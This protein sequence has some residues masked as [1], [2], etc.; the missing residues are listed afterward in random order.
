MAKKQSKSRKSEGGGGKQL[1]EE[2]RNV[3]EG[4]SPRMKQLFHA[5]VVPALQEKFG[6]TNPMAQPRLTKIILNVGMGKS[7]EGAKLNPAHKEQVIKDLTVISGQKPIMVRARKS[8]SNFK[9]REGMESG[10]MVTIRGDRMWELLDRMITLAIPRIKDF[11]GLPTKS[12]DHG[13]NYTFGVT[14][15]AIFPEVDMANASFTH[16]MHVTLGFRN[17]DPAKSRLVLETMG[18]PFRKPEE[19]KQRKAG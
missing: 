2:P 7:L 16:G 12:F 14:E 4:Y 11:R 18:F 5:E 8:V 9:V 15:Q 17:S 3:P 19:Q 13:G 1:A 6:L 10:C